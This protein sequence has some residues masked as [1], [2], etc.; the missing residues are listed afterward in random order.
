[1][2]EDC[3]DRSRRRAGL[4]SAL[5]VAALTAGLVLA[6]T[7]EPPTGCV[8]D[9][10]VVAASVVRSDSPVAQLNRWDT[11][12]LVVRNRDGADWRGVEAAIAGVQLAADGRRHATG[13]YVS[14]EKKHVPRGAAVAFDLGGFENSRGGRWA[15][16]T[17]LATDVE[18]TLQRDGVSCRARVIVAGA[19]E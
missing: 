4:G 15:G 1:M 10:P 17:M 19:V 6:C 8:L 9:G 5:V 13:R 14:D 16:Q 18:L 3:C 11:A 12:V 2:P 7:Q